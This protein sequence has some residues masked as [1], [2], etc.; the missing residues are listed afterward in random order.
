M[1]ELPAW[2]VDFSTMKD[3]K[4]YSEEGAPAGIYDPYIY[5][6][7][8]Y[9]AYLGNVDL[10]D[11]SRVEITYCCDGTEITEKRFAASPSLA[12]GLKSRD[13][14]YGYEQNVDFDGDIAHTEMVFSNRS[15]ATGARDAV[16]DL[17]EINYN[18]DVWLAIHNPNATFVGILEIRFYS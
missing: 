4:A 2:K 11:Y 3:Q 13:S 1:P 5:L 16:I 15:W 12:I 8:G 17:S 6:K 14:S 10:S 18:G 9:T 7:F